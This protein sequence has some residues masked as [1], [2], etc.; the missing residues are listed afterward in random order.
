MNLDHAEE[1]ARCIK[2]LAHPIRLK[3]LACLKK[4]PK[5]VQSINHFV[6]TSQANVSQHL[7][8]MRDRGFLVA[9]KEA[10]FV[11]YRVADPQI[12]ILLA[13]I[14]KLF[15][16]PENNSGQ[17]TIQTQPAEKEKS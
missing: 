15:C 2:M 1:A 10:N 13:L 5:N 4:G 6:R 7:N 17:I 9:R 8:M 12:Y 14:E 16:K 11:Y 3:I